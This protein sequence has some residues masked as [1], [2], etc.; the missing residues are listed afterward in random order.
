[1]KI[2][3]LINSMRVV[4]GEE[5]FHVNAGGLRRSSGNPRNHAYLLLEL[6]EYKL[7]AI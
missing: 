6:G 5:E 3:L 2:I 4:E 1:M 7:N